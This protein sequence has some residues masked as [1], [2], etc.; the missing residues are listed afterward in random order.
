MA[1][2]RTD[3]EEVSVHCDEQDGEGREE[4][5]GGLAGAHQLVQS[6]LPS[7]DK[8]TTVKRTLPCRGTPCAG[9]AASSW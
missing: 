5:A 1:A 9:R 7:M 6:D 8:K 2:G 3:D 4:D